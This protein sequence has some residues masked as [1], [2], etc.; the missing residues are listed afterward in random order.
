[1]K[2]CFISYLA[3]KAVVFRII[4][5]VRNLFFWTLLAVLTQRGIEPH[6][7]IIA[8]S[9]ATIEGSQL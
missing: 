4:V 5:C 3:E 9:V 1:M 2:P 8:I 6:G 7:V